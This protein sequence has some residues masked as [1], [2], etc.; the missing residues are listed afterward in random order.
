MIC[1]LLG[2]KTDRKAP[3]TR[4]KTRI[5]SSLIPHQMCFYVETRR[6]TTEEIHI[7]IG[8]FYLQVRLIV[9]K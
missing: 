3:L 4:G 1:Q 8:G 9:I 5:L 7:Y 2:A 6:L